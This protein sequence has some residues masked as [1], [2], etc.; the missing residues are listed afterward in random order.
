MAA[1]TKMKT[2]ASLVFKDGTSNKFWRIE[3]DG[4]EHT[5]CFGRVGTDGQT[6]TKSFDSEEAAKKSCDKLIAE[7]RK[8]GYVDEGSSGGTSAVNKSATPAKA[9]S[10]AKVKSTATS[11]ETS[12]VTSKTKAKGKPKDKLDAPEEEDVV[13]A[14]PSAAVVT[15]V[16]RSIGLEPQDWFRAKFR[17]DE[18]LKRGEPRPF[19]KEACVKALGKLKTINYGWD[20]KWEDLHLPAAL[21]KEEAHFWLL[22]MTKERNR[23][24]KMVKF[25]ETIEKLKADGQ[26]KAAEAWSLI[27]K[28]KRTVESEVMHAVANL[29]SPEEIVNWMLTERKGKGK[30]R[31]QEAIDHA[32]LVGGFDLWVRPYLSDK[33]VKSLQKLV[34]AKI[35]PTAVPDDYEAFPMAHY[36]AASLGMHKELLKITS[37]WEDACYQKLPYASHYQQPHLLVCGLA[38]AELV[39]SEW[40]RLKIPI[41]KPE[42]ARALIACTEYSALDILADEICKLT[43][44]DECTAL[45]KVLALVNAP[46]A[47]EPMLRCKVESKSPIVAR[48]WLDTNVGNAVSGLI[49]VA[50]GRGKLADAAIEYLRSVKRNGLEDVIAA[51]VKQAGKSEAAAKVQAEVLDRE[52]KVYEPHD[53]K[54]TPKWLSEALSKA[55]ASKKKLPGWAA[56]AHL[57]PL[58]IGDRRLNDQQLDVVLQKLVTT[59]V[60][61]KDELLTLLREKVE[62]NVR[63]E[64]AWKIFQHWQDDGCPSKEKWAM[65]TLG[66]LGDDGCVLK[67]TPMIRVWPGESQHARAVFG[68]E[69]LRA[70]GSS[71]ALMQLS[72]IAQKLKFKGL[73]TKAAEFVDQIAKEKGMTRDELEDRVVPDCGLDEQ[74]KREFSFGS[75]SFSFV[76]G[77]DLKAMVRDE[78]GKVRTDLPKP[79]G[80]DDATVAN[81]SVAEWKLLKKQIKEVATIQSARLENA[82]VTGRR[83]SQ[84]DFQTLVVRH[85]LMTHLAQKLIWATFDAKGKTS[86]TFRI[87]EERD[88]ADV[89]DESLDLPKDHFV[90]LVHPLEMTE[91]ERAAWGEVLSDYEIIAPFAQLGRDV[92][93]LEKS[94]EKAESLDRF[95][96]LKLVAPTLVFTL[97]KMGWIRGIGMDGGCFDEHSKQFPAANVT[98][99]VHYDGTVGM[100]YIDPEEMLTL[101]D[102]YFIPGMRQPSGYGWEEKNVKKAK[103]GT[104]NPIV[105]SEVLADMQVLKSKAK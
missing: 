5:V 86:S 100:G 73:K 85:P 78:T 25:A 55:S 51:T 103:L 39:E 30:Q 37:A 16:T 70:I 45:L 92:N 8:K 87:T 90:G 83:W 19:D 13:T 7:K 80:K 24:T 47:A 75:R 102:V 67:L 23:D 77:S 101:E 56:A 66:H 81:E 32:Q 20:A 40:R 59:N 26:I 49:D 104:V 35:D 44:R 54:S 12:T 18:S 22:A 62:K 58:I 63:D 61:D 31:W 42:Q 17:K 69:C 97:E 52:E 93:R 4:K 1:E 84:E 10:A 95:K 65:G 99:V 91:D 64:F 72:G 88:Y 34:A 74:G 21:S 38:S 9:K 29:F 36:L 68:L 48:D 28:T 11:T 89:S 53:A 94:E 27:E 2:S 14:A 76:L 98:A 96:G 41:A 15:G 57:P 6:Q 82:M 105:I 3:L 50:G 60:T 43:N 79:S 71:V 33:E 46:E